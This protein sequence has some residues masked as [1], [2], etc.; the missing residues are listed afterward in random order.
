M[1]TKG[2][3][4][5]ILFVLVMFSVYTIC[6]L[7][8]SVIGANVY[9]NNA[10]NSETAYNTRTSVLYLTEKIR[11]ND[12]EN[13]IELREWEGSDML[14]LREIYGEDIYETLIYVEDGYLCEVSIVAGK[15]PVRGI[16]EQIMPLTSISFDMTIPRLL[17]MDIV[18][19][20]GTLHS[21][22]IYLECTVDLQ[23]S[24]VGA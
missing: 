8:L 19:D 24:E 7:F 23:R 1:K 20:R 14:V 2:N 22:G 3:I 18:D 9:E 21:S 16:G 17:E 5:N 12:T 6:A 4:A 11:Q 15:D 10:D 13:A